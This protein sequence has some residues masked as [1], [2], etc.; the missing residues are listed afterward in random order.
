M[1]AINN[2]WLTMITSIKKYDLAVAYRIYPKIS[3]EPFFDFNS[4]L[5]L[6]E[7]SLHSFREATNTLQIKI[8]A[9]LDDCPPNYKELFLKYFPKGDLEFIILKGEGN[10]N[11]FHRQIEILCT[12]KDSDLVYFAEDDYLYMPGQSSLLTGFLHENPGA[13]VSPYDHS[14]NY[15]YEINQRGNSIKLFNNHHFR[16]ANSTC[17]TFMTSCQTLQRTR[18][19]FESYSDGNHDASLWFSLTKPNFI[20]P[21]WHLRQMFCDRF[22][23]SLAARAWRYCSVQILAGKKRQLWVPIPSIA[24]HLDK[25][26]VA[27]AVDWAKIK[28]ELEM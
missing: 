5:E 11:T 17:L 14:D 16:T 26:F 21:L 19:V 15:S 1:Q 9:L 3:K 22:V 24:T 28:S 10:R 18:K 25:P 12:Q 13:F 23:M 20:Y 2:C 4:K 7:L 27:P 8:W 6:A